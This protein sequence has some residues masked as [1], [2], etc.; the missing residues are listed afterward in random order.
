MDR[1]A[2]RHLPPRWILTVWTPETSACPNSFNIY[3]KN[4][5]FPKD[6]SWRWWGSMCGHRKYLRIPL[7]LQLWEAKIV[8]PPLIQFQVFLPTYKKQS[9]TI[10]WMLRRWALICKQLSE[11]FEVK[12]LQREVSSATAN[13][14]LIAQRLPGKEAVGSLLCLK[15]N[16]WQECVR[17]LCLASSVK[18][19]SLKIK[20]F[21]FMM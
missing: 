6:G 7:W 9:N 4:G 1:N 19:S 10:H 5:L 3:F 8:L 18:R 20:A 17:S 12:D 21:I 15:W 2:F 16:S 11:Q 13:N 14:H